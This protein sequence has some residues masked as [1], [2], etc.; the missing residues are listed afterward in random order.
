MKWHKA[1]KKPIII[2]F[3]EVEGEKEEIRTK[4]GILTA[5]RERD[6]I[7]KGIKGELYPIDKEIFEE[8]YE[9]LRRT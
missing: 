1:R 8:T 3:R 4:E 5:L 2:E 6:Y 7:I 9:R